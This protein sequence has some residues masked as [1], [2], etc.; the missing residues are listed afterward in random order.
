MQLRDQ[1]SQN[2]EVYKCL[3]MFIT[4]FISINKFQAH[5]KLKIE[6]I[7]FNNLTLQSSTNIILQILTN[8]DVIKNFFE[9]I[10]LF[11]FFFMYFEDQSKKSEGKQ[12]TLV[13]LN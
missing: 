2:R 1:S 11:I 7:N 10:S 5:S 3:G 8:V 9:D 12:F 13:H 4:I 6:Y